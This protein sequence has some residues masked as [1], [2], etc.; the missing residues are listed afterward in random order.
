LINGVAMV[1]L[2]A[3]FA[4]TID[5][6]VPYHVM[7][8]PDGDTRGLFVASKGPNGFVVREVQGGRGSLTFDYHIYAPA[9]GHPND[10]MAVVTRDIASSIMPKALPTMHRITRPAFR[11]VPKSPRKRIWGN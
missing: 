4:Q 5:P 3:A 2:D 9:L 6:R 7:L 8:T 11:Q 10:R 1:A